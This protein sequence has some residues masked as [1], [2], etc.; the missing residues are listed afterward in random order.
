MIKIYFETI[1]TN[2]HSHYVELH[3]PQN[4]VPEPGSISYI[5]FMVSFVK[6]LI[7]HFNIKLHVYNCSC[8]N[9]YTETEQKN[10]VK[11]PLLAIS[12]ERIFT[13]FFC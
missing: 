6:I 5:F 4:Y 10:G 9:N 3:F 11:I 12:S 8:K 13:P 2:L 7:S 1:M